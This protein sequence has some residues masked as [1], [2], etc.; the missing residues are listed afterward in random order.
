MFIMYT[1]YFI[2]RVTTVKSCVIINKMLIKRRNFMAGLKGYS[3]DTVSLR[4]IQKDKYVLSSDIMAKIG[5]EELNSQMR[6]VL[7]NN[8]KVYFILQK[9]EVCGVVI[10]KFEKHLASEFELEDDKAKTE[11][12]K[13]DAF[14]SKVMDKAVEVGSKNKKEMDKAVA[15]NAYKLENLYLSEEL[16]G[17]ED[18]IRDDLIEELKSAIAFSNL[19][20]KVIIWGEYIIADKTIGKAGESA[21]AIGICLGLAVGVLYGIVIDNLSLGMCLGVSIGM[22]LGTAYYGKAKRK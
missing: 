12:K 7:S 20:I 17:K 22:L 6:D 15:A 14:G 4:K 10:M 11:E 5:R 8:G 21:I 18:V 1:T 13:T 16:T 2:Q 3:Y 19:E 9:K